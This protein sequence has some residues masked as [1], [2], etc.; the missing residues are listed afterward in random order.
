MT[1]G[2]PGKFLQRHIPLIAQ[3]GKAF[4]GYDRDK[5]HNLARIYSGKEHAIT[6]FN[7]CPHIPRFVKPF[8][9][10]EHRDLT[11]SRHREDA[12]LLCMFVEF[13]AQRTIASARAQASGP[14]TKFTREKQ[15]FVGKGKTIDRVEKGHAVTVAVLRFNHNANE[16]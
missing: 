15:L 7:Y 2:K 12:K 13:I 6:V 14:R 9:H 3:G 1:Q 11:F 8:V 5:T 4:F 10:R 16:R